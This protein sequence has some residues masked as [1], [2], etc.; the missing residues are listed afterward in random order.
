MSRD[1]LKSHSFTFNDIRARHTATRTSTPPCSLTQHIS[2]A[3]TSGTRGAIP[4]CDPLH[5]HAQHESTHTHDNSTPTKARTSLDSS[6]SLLPAHA[7]CCYIASRVGALLVP[8]LDPLQKSLQ[9]AIGRPK[10]TQTLSA[11]MAKARNCMQPSPEETACVLLSQNEEC[12][13]LIVVAAVV[14]LMLRFCIMLP[15]D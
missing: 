6:L 7:A 12:D 5:G 10:E 8:I 15:L 14:V 3:G 4:S 13:Q 1:C 11:K 9:I 2:M